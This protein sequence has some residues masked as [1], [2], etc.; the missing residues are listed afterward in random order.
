[1]KLLSLPIL[2]RVAVTLA[3]AAFAIPAAAQGADAVLRDFQLTGDWVVEVAGKP[4]AKAEVYLS[5][6]VPAFL[7]VT[8]ELASPTL[9]VPREQTVNTVS[10]M[11]LAKRGATIDVLA[12][13]EVTPVGR[14][15]LAGEEVRFR[16]D[17]KAVVMKPRPHLLGDQSLAGMLDHSPDYRRKAS[18]YKPDTAALAALKAAR[19][20]VRVR[21]YFGSWCPFCSQHVPSLLRV[22]EEL[23]GTRVSF[24]FYGL[25]QG[26]AFAADA[27]A[28]RDDV[29][30]VP[31][32]IVYVGGKEAGRIEGGEWSKPE[33]TL[34]EIVSSRG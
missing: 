29:H 34:R 19:Q 5:Q 31:T 12:D 11:K 23:A 9:L 14:V 3:A 25:P 10:F 21:V 4:A 33:Q 24:E 22:A 13:A 30:S 1:M 8:P 18:A 15:T 7:I 28:K 6:R 32:G 2:R 16:V 17:G 27:M 20:P 26:Q